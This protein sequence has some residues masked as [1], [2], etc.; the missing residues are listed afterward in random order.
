VLLFGNEAELQLPSLAGDTLLR[1]ST[2][3]ITAAHYL[4]LKAKTLFL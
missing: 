3:K 1:V 2:E 4:F